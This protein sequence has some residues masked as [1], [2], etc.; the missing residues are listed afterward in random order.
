MFKS[1]SW[2]KTLCHSFYTD[3]VFC[4]C[5]FLVSYH[6]TNLRKAYVTMVTLLN[7][8]LQMYHPIFY[9]KKYK[10]NI[11][12][13]WNAVIWFLTSVH[14]Q[15]FYKSTMLWEILCHTS[16]IYKVFYQYGSSYVLSKF[17][18][19]ICFPR[20]SALNFYTTTFNWKNALHL[21]PLCFCHECAPPYI[22]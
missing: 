4:P 5:L 17:E 16:C 20:K 10:D 2:F 14:S 9:Q 18:Y 22:N 19:L 6:I 1:Y 3:K 7:V 11:L 12:V 21:L 15:M 13:T 8:I